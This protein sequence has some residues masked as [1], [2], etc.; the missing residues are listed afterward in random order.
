MDHELETSHARPGQ[1]T[2]VSTTRAGAARPRLAPRRGPGRARALTVGIVVCAAITGG[3]VAAGWSGG[4]APTPG[5]SEFVSLSASEIDTMLMPI[6]G[7]DARASMR[8]NDFEAGVARNAANACAGVAKTDAPL[9]VIPADARLR[10]YEDPA[11]LRT[12]G[13][14]IIANMRTDAP[15]KT[16]TA[17]STPDRACMQ[18]GN[19]AVGRIESLVAPIRDSWVRTVQSTESS[20]AVQA[21]W[22]KW[23]ACMQSAGYALENEDGFN[24]L[25]DSTLSKLVGAGDIDGA[26]TAELT[27]ARAFADCLGDVVAA[28]GV[29]RGEARASL[30]SSRGAEISAVRSELNDAIRDAGRRHDVSF[31]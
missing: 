16:A 10:L 28:R 23:S 22:S 24:R 7:A 26:R 17:A 6:S 29:A 2:P 13:L 3:A 11:I 30:V 20:P 9:P 21:A 18:A 27:L 12:S 19:A 15:T 14:G 25:V 31:G 5:E 8:L 4:T 1:S